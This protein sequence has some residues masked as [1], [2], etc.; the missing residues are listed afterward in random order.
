M[1]SIARLSGQQRAAGY[2]KSA[3]RSSV[4]RRGRGAA[5]RPA[6]ECPPAG[7]VPVALG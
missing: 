4:R 7:A 5:G 3:P 2:N 1:D 6:G